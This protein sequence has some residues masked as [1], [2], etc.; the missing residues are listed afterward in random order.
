MSVLP[1]EKI[2]YSSL[3]KLR[4]SLQEKLKEVEAAYRQIGSLLPKLLNKNLLPRHYEFI[5][6]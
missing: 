5:L 3:V 4:Q 1:L 6:T 2:D